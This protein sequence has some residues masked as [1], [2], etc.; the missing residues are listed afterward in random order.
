MW[1]KNKSTETSKWVLPKKKGDSWRK[2][3]L[4]REAYPGGAVRGVRAF[5]GFGFH[6]EGGRSKKQCQGKEIFLREG[7]IIFPGKGA[8][9]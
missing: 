8:L 9:E 1:K 5:W 4:F 6:G 2:G 3:I 7:V